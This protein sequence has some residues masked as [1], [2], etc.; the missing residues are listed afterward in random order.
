MIQAVTR[1]RTIDLDRHDWTLLRRISERAG[2]LFFRRTFHLERAERLLS[3]GLLSKSSALYAM[4]AGG[5][6]HV[7]RN[8]YRIT[9]R[10]LPRGTVLDSEGFSGATKREIEY[11]AEKM[12]VLLSTWDINSNDYEV[13]F[14]KTLKI[15]RIP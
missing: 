2:G 9:A 15:K 11:G 4:R 8:R 12:H 1:R 10:G 14:C 13:L 3:Q 7:Y 6:V 5:T